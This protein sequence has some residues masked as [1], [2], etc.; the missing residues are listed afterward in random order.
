MKN[1]KWTT[2][3]LGVCSL[4]IATALLGG[5]PA[6]GQ[7]TNVPMTKAEQKKADKEAKRAAKEGNADKDRNYAADP[8]KV[9][10]GEFKAVEIKASALAPRYQK[11]ANEKSADKIDEMLQQQLKYIFPNLKVIPP[12]GEFSK[13]GERTLQITP[14]IEKIHIVATGARIWVGAMAGGSDIVMHVDYRD[15][16]TGKI[17]AHPDFWRGN[18][19][20]AGGWSMGGTDNQ[21][22]D[23]VV[24]QIAAYTTGNK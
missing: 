8:T 13:G 9:R 3:L 4:A 12:G 16:S 14:I 6:S 19:A 23:A 11:K 17:I 10:F 15:S 20:W 24:A 2:L 7:E 22:R 5:T 18:N 21:I 1:S